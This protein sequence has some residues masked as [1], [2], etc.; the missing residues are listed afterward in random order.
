M[1]KP[2]GVSAPFSLWVAVA[3]GAL[4]PTGAQAQMMGGA[5]MGGMM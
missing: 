3:V 5:T 1:M 4:V 2:A